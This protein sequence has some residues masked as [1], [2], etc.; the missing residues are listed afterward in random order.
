MP[1]AD[2]ETLLAL[3]EGRGF[4][5]RRTL[6]ARAGQFRRRSRDQ[7]IIGFLIAVGIW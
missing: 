2:L 4:R 3:L 5:A 6:A 7:R 1:P